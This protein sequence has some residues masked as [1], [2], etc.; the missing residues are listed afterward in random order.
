MKR[1]CN[2]KVIKELSDLTKKKQDEK[3]DVLRVFKERL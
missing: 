2:Q 3:E 1:E